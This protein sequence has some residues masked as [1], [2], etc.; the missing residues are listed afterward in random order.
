MVKVYTYRT[1][2]PIVM[3]AGYITLYSNG[4]TV[5]QWHTALN[6]INIIGS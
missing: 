1:D 4:Y 6:D 5:A 2:E 3:L